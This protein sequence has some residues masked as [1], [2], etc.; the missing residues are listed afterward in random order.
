M[1]TVYR[2]L[3]S[4]EHFPCV[5]TFIESQSF[6]PPRPFEG[7]RGAV[8]VL[9]L[10]LRKQA[11]KVELICQGL[12]ASPDLF[13]QLLFKEKKRFTWYNMSKWLDW[14]FHL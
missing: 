12:K 10:K 14:Y 8:R 7:S 2:E 4:S 5:V 3:Q 13:F 11:W 6:Y 9:L 1:P